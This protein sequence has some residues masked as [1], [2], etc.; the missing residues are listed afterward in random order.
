MYLKIHKKI[1]KTI[2]D[3]IF[4]FV[5]NLNLKIKMSLKNKTIFFSF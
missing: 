3:Q 2:F 4:N 5:E 1:T